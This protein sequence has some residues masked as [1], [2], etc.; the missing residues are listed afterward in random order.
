MKVAGLILVIFGMFLWLGVL[1]FF[2][3]LTRD[4][5]K[6]RAPETGV[7]VR[8]LAQVSNPVRIWREHRNHFP[9]SS[10]R[11]AMIVLAVATIVC[12]SLGLYLAK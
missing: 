10:Q 1:L 3:A 2:A 9:Y 6:V 11:K 12:V 7:R 5:A 8:K 4:V